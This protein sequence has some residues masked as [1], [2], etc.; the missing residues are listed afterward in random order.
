VAADRNVPFVRITWM[1]QEFTEGILSVEV[2]DDDQLTDRATIEFEDAHRIAPSEAHPEEIVKVEL[3]WQGEPTMLFEGRVT[4]SDAEGAA[5]SETSRLVALDFSDKLRGE[6]I[7]L[8][9]TGTLKQII[10]KIITGAGLTEGQIEP[11]PNT[12]YLKAQPLAQRNK[13]NLEFIQSLARRSL[14]RSYVELNGGVSKFYYLPIRRIIQAEP[15]GTL[16]FC[17]GTHQLEEFSVQRVATG[18]DPIR[19]AS[20]V[21]PRTG[22]VTTGTPEPPPPSTPPTGTS[23]AVEHAGTRAGTVAEQVSTA[24]ASL[25]AAE[26][27]RRHNAAGGASDPSEATA[28]AQRDPTR[29]QGMLGNGV[30][31]GN[32][33]IRAKGKI[34]IIGV[35]PSADGDWYVKQVRHIYQR[36]ESRGTYVTRFVATR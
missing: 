29:L 2:E 12:E 25:P 18:G 28:S 7:T 13:T 9:H 33:N 6:P 26:S 21:D 22:E 27:G 31:N 30:I 16:Y 15:M 36:N 1:T 32:V 23:S 35:S 5:E 17:T 10:T 14:H 8:D 19:T 4:R 20:R 3:G 34:K 11:D 24:T